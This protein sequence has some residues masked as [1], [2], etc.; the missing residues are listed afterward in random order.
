V[1]L[2]GAYPLSTGFPGCPFEGMIIAKRKT[3]P[4]K[5]FGII[6][7]VIIL[8]IITFLNSEEYY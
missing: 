6:E 4:R 7:P 3:M 1:S 8:F 2:T 5:T